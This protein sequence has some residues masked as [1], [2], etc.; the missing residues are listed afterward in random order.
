MYFQSNCMETD[1]MKQT[2]LVLVLLGVVFSPNLWAH[3]AAEGIVADDIWY[4]IDSN[5]EGSPHLDIDFTDPSNLNMDIDTSTGRTFLVSTMR[6]DFI[7]DEVDS[8]EA[9]IL[10]D[11][12]F[13]DAFDTTVSG[14]GQIPSGT[15]SYTVDA[16]VDDSDPVDGYIDYAIISIMEPIGQGESQVIPTDS[17]APGQRAGG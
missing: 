3:H 17:Q 5:L 13:E 1:E 14:M 6:V 11:I 10:I 8:I 4:M 7:D 15:I 9:M 16:L 12:Y 2:F